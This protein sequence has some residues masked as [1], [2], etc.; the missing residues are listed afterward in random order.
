MICNRLILVNFMASRCPHLNTV[1]NAFHTKHLPLPATQYP[2]HHHFC[3]GGRIAVPGSS[4]SL[5]PSTGEAAS[6]L[7]WALER[8]LLGA[9]NP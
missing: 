9:P 5:A 3:P 1:M 8:K 2:H 6:L 4:Q 7:V